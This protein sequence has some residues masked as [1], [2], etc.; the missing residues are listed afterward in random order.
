MMP[1]FKFSSTITWGAVLHAAVLVAAVAVAYGQIGAYAEETRRAHD[2]DVTVLRSEASLAIVEAQGSN[3]LL[4]QQMG[5]VI[6]TLGEI[7][8]EIKELRK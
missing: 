5:Q 3:R 8:Q 2:S 4:V 1:R 7:K 6:E